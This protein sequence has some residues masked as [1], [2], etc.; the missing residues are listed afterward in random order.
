MMKG[1]MGRL[2]RAAAGL[3]VLLA[4]IQ[5][6]PLSAGQPP[7]G[8]YDLAAA[9]RLGGH[10]LARHVGKTDAELRDRLAR[11]T[12]ISAASTYADR[13][14]AERIVADT[15]DRFR[16][17]LDAWLRRSGS[18]P[19]LVLDYRG[20]PDVVIGRT[21]KRGESRTRPCTDAVVVL[22][23]RNDGRYYVLT[24]YPERRR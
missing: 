9:E 20:A 18:R 2:T 22:R 16:A 19:N 14:T 11:E 7:A 12:G 10:T 6:P 8:R 5:G 23:W 13:D 21:L 15:L 1:R 24:S 17:R 4:V 3:A